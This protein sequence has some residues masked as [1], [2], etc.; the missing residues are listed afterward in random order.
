LEREEAFEAGD[1]TWWGWE[2]AVAKLGIKE[3]E[4]ALRRVWS[5]VINELHTEKDHAEILGRLNRAAAAPADRALFDEAD[6]RSI[7]DPVEAVAWVE[8]RA[9]MIAKWRT[10]RE[11]DEGVAEKNDPAKAVC[12]TDDECDWLAGFLVSPQV[13]DNTMTLEM[14]DGFL[15][16]LVIGP[17]MVMPSEYLRVIWGTD[18]DD[19][20]LWDSVAQ[21][22]YFMNLLTKHWNAIAARR[23]ADAPHDPFIDTFGDAEQGRPSGLC[24]ITRNLAFSFVNK[25]TRRSNTLIISSIPEADYSRATRKDDRR[26]DAGRI[27]SSPGA[28]LLGAWVLMAAQTAFAPRV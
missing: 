27:G 21:A 3:L 19:G 12:L 15:T 14:L 1:S 23:D 28:T 17:A 18:D 24:S 13:P 10:E 25:K 6:V 26:H 7:E 8:R 22:Q 20:P 5:K 16:A 2:D 4:P 11:A 9:K